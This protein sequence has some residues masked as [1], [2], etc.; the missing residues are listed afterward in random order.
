MGLR[1][2]CPG[3]PSDVTLYNPKLSYGCANVPVWLLLGGG[4][5]A[6]P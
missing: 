2:C 4:C 3:I 1:Q 5:C 6:L